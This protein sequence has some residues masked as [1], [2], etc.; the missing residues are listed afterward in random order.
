MT[1]LGARPGFEDSRTFPA[2]ILDNLAGTRQKETRSETA[3]GNK[4]EQR[5]SRVFLVAGE[6]SLHSTAPRSDKSSSLTARLPQALELE[7]I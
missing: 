1:L 4:R 2:K 7:P 3:G 6:A 5:Q